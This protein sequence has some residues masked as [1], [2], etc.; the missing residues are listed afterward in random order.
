MVP[1]IWVFLVIISY[2]LIAHCLKEYIHA[3][4][5][6][7]RYLFNLN[8]FPFWQLLGFWLILFSQNSSQ[9]R[10]KNSSCLLLI[11]NSDWILCYSDTTVYDTI[12]YFPVFWRS[13]K[14]DT[15]IYLATYYHFKPSIIHDRK[16]SIFWGSSVISL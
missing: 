16:F 4:K 3:A 9:Y 1:K 2:A 13:N 5:N 6:E 11:S 7:M 12:G 8:L 15:C 10:I 14:V